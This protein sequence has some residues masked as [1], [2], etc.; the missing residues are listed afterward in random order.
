M[1][2]IRMKLTVLGL[3]M[4]AASALNGYNSTQ[5]QNLIMP[6]GAAIDQMTNKIGTSNSQQLTNMLNELQ[7]K[8]NLLVGQITQEAKS[9]N[10]D[11]GKVNKLVQVIGKIAV[12]Q[13][14]RS[15]KK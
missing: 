5:V 3:A 12:I 6:L 9:G 4:I 15:C 8:K 1:K 2:N 11:D 13:G 7:S 14:S 10:V